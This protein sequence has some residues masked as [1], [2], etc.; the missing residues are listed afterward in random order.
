L[1][2]E[3]SGPVRVSI[4]MPVYNGAATVGEAIS[5]LLA[6]TFADF[7]LLISDNGSDDETES[8]CRA[9]AAADRRVRYVRQPVNR[10]G[11]ANFAFVLTET[12]APYFMW[13]ACDDVWAPQYLETVVQLLDDDPA[14]VVAF[15]F[16]QNFSM[17]T[18]DWVVQ[19]TAR[20]ETHSRQERVRRFILQNDGY[21]KANLIYGLIRRSMLGGAFET[22]RTAPYLSDVLFVFDLLLRGPCRIAPKIL[23]FKRYKPSP[24]I[25]WG[26]VLFVAEDLKYSL[27]HVKVARLAGASTVFQGYIL[28]LASCKYVRDLFMWTGW[29]MQAVKRRLR[30]LAPV[31]QH[32]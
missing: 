26:T 7:D 6:Q 31:E 2:P 14:A 1:L 24:S 5:S 22:F 18:T 11:M 13:A 3:G 12:K 17:P 29:M 25:P 19:K 32:P 23:F 15:T 30:R 28:I 10:G 9:L 8:I 20:F 4:G 21:G 16:V 27:R